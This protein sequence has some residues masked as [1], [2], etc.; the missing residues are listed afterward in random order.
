[1]NYIVLGAYL[2]DSMTIATST[3]ING[4]SACTIFT[5]SVIICVRFL[6]RYAH[7]KKNLL[8]FVGIMFLCFSGLY[9]GPVVTFFSIIIA[10]QNISV[11]LYA[12][13]SYSFSTFAISD[14]MWLGF[15][16]FNPNRKKI[17]LCV[18][19]LTGIPYF[20]ALY[21]FP[22]QM[23]MLSASSVS[24]LNLAHKMINISLT[25]VLFALSAF[26]VLSFVFILT[27]GFYYLQ[28]KITGFEQKKATYLALGYFILGIG[29]ILEI[30]LGD[31]GDLAKVS[32]RVLVLIAISLLYIG[33]S[34][35]ESRESQRQDVK[36]DKN[37]E[38]K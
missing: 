34:T 15:T 22:N 23:I 35:R 4:I 27:G 13:L 32:A 26:Y 6:V 33:F 30:A 19:L 24:A 1:M 9:L 21:G 16:L 12:Q 25:S 2:S 28:R 5:L 37:I 29:F 31:L 14:V 17:V 8:P 18:Y 10:N 20:I 38:A 7:T 11:T 36:A 3:L